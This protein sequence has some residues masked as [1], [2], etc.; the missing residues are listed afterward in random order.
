MIIA[1]G[2]TLLQSKIKKTNNKFIPLD[3]E[4]FSLINSNINKKYIQKIYITASGG[5][6]YFKKKINLNNVSSQKSIISS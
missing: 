5:P 4:H 6:F 1:G 3:S 2:E